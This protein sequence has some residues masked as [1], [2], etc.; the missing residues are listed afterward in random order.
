MF[1]ISNQQTLGESEEAIIK[2]LG[3]VLKTI[4]DHEMNARLKSLER[5]GPKLLDKIGRAYGVLLNAHVL[6]SNEAMNLLSLIRLAVDFNML[7]EEDR[8]LVDRLFIECQPGHVQYGFGEGIEPE[9]RDIARATRL[10]EE[11]SKLPPLIF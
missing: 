1:Q 8:G 3:A 6:S 11:F 5:N 10:R 4:I 2:R 7:R 9:V